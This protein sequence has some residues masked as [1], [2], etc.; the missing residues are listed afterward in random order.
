MTE[1][2]PYGWVITEDLI[3]NG[4]YNG[5]MGPRTMDPEL[6]ARLEAGEGTEFRL[7]DD[8]G[9]HYATGRIIGPAD[10]DWGKKAKEYEMVEWEFAPLHEFGARNWGCT[11]VQYKND[12]GE[13][14]NL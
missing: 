10:P 5:V 9:E 6:E 1:Y 14:K 2:T 11:D 8:D 4:E 13:W 7:L 12:A 3:T